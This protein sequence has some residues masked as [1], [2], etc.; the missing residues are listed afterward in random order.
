MA[1]YLISILAQ[2][3]LQL[4]S[5]ELCPREIIVNLSLRMSICRAER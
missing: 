2:L 5:R 1:V 3:T 4:F